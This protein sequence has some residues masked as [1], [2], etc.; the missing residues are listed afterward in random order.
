MNYEKIYHD[1]IQNARSKNRDRKLGY[2]ENH[3]VIPKS[4]GGSNKKDNLVLLT[5]KE[6]FVCHVLLVKINKN[7]KPNYVKMLHALMLMKGS[8]SKQYRYINARLYETIKKEYSIIRS[9]A[10][11]GKPMSEEQKQKI[12]CKMKGQ[13]GHS[14]S[15]ETRAKISEKAKSRERKPFSDEYKKRHSEIMKQKH[16]WKE[17]GG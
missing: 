8:T 4:L 9:E 17:K 2:F 6:H 16:R 3:H 10:T 12:S 1:I 15:D 13:K 7:N 5:A 11:K 14:I